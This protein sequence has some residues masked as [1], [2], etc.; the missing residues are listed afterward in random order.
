MIIHPIKMF[1]NITYHMIFGK[2]LIL[3][4]G[5][6]VGLCMLTTAVFGWLTLQGKVKIG[7]HKVFA[8]ITIILA[9]V[10][11]FLGFMAYF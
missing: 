9:L 6:V 11:G 3:Y 5:L 2:P 10:H 7:Y 8:A 4:L 1:N